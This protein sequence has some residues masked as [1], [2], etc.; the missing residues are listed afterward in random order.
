MSVKLE[1][2]RVYLADPHKYATS[3]RRAICVCVLECS[4]AAPAFDRPRKEDNVR[5][6]S[7]ENDNVVTFPRVYADV[8]P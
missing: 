6:E 7:A 1:N 5:R 3:R 2:E 4:A 8:N